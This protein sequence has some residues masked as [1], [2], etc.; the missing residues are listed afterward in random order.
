MSS[1]TSAGDE[2]TTMS[3]RRDTYYRA[4]AA[5][6]GGETFDELLTRLVRENA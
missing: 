6:R 5:K 1:K 2:W 4:R 3:V